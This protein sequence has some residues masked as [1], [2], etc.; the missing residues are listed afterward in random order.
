MKKLIFLLLPIICI[1]WKTKTYTIYET[2]RPASVEYNNAKRIIGKSWNINWIYADER[3]ANKLG[4]EAMGNH[5]D[6]VRA[7]I[8]KDKGDK[9][10]TLFYNEVQHELRVHDELRE[11]IRQKREFKTIEDKAFEPIILFETKN[12]EKYIVHIVGQLKEDEK[13][14][15]QT[16]CKFNIQKSTPDF[17]MN[18]KKQPLTICFPENNIK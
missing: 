2:G 5:N 11:R 7:L 6:S 3:V 12:R 15:F 14:A 18:C 16:L 13:R 9:W 17:S 8:A 1:S 4:H 10:Q